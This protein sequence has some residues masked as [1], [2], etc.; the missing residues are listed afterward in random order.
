ME[1]AEKIRRG[2]TDKGK[3]WDRG[4]F[5]CCLIFYLFFLFYDGPVWCVDSA[6]Y[7]TMDITR[8]PLY[9]TL[10]WAFRRLFGEGRY[11]MSVAALQSLLAAYAAWKLAVT[12]KGYQDGSRLLAALAA[13]FQGGV[14]LLNRFVAQRGSSYT[15][16]IMTEGLGFPLYV[17][18]VVQLYKYV[19]EKKGRN[20]AGTMCYALL[21]ISLRK[22]M[23]LTLC[24]MAAVFVLYY[25]VKKR[26]PRKLLGLLLLTAAVFLT[27]KFLDRFYNYQVRGAWIEHSGN[28][29]GALCTLFYASE[30]QDAALFRDDV[31]RQFYLEINGEAV[32]KGYKLDEAP[33]DWAGMANHYAD[34]YDDIGYGIINPVIQ[35]HIRAGGEED[36]IEAALQFDRYCSS[37]LKTLLGKLSGQGGSRLLRVFLANI[38]AGFVNSVARVHRF[39]N[40]YA[41]LVYLLYFGLYLWGMRNGKRW[42]TPDGTQTLAEIVFLGLAVNCGV[43]GLT[44]FTQPRYMIYSMGLF[45]C[46]LSVMLHD[47]AKQRLRGKT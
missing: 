43:V 47:A 28:S 42:G 30:E 23:L 44:I 11:L 29:M 26:E 22:Q 21:L 37:M 31:L 36:P 45:Y 2:I 12:V 24:L 39:L 9:P 16:S 3:R 6:S 27:G 10:L 19:M 1:W 18:F 34:C 4:L 20:L 46:A 38:C 41:L 14:T 13:G 33:K 35:G 5:A 8:E 15:V 25:L 32:A 40:G 17:L 7:A